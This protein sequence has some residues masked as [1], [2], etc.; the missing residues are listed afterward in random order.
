MSQNAMINNA[1]SNQ[2]V[3]IKSEFSP[4]L[5]VA[6]TFPSTS[7]WTKQS[8]KD[9]CDINTIM[10][11]YQSSGEIPNINQQA[12]QY[13][14]ATGFDYQEA[15]QFVAG[16]QSLF[17]DLPSEIRNRFNNDPAAFLDFTSQEK[18]RPEMAE[19]GLLNPPML[20]P[21][22]PG[23]FDSSK[24]LSPTNELKNEP[25]PDSKPAV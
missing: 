2:P 24:P 15:M 19:M 20:P 6:I 1:N 13:L 23:A 18:N 10:R 25:L 14:D 8:F 9:E 17:M 7:R 22:V 21:I 5:K 12:P 11:R 16:A 3:E 4:K